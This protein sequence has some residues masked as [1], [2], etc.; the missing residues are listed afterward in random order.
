MAYAEKFLGQVRP[1]A[2]ATPVSIFAP[3]AGEIVVVKGIHVANPTGT[4]RTYRIYHHNTGAT[5]D[6]TTA[7]YYNVNLAA[8]TSIHLPVFIV[9]DNSAG[10]LAVEASAASSLTFTAYG[11]QTV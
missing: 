3:G 5:Y 8:N 9:M 7:L 11:V 1:S 6:A 4:A 10:N 2:A